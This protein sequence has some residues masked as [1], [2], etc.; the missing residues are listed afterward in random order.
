MRIPM[1]GGGR[2]GGGIG[3]IIILVVI[4]LRRRTCCGIDLMQI[5]GGGTGTVPRAAAAR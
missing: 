1:G 3:T 2:A 4:Y 5:L